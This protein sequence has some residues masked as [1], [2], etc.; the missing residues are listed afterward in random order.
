MLG[1]GGLLGMTVSSVG[2]IGERPS[3]VRRSV[4]I[5]GSRSSDISG[6]CCGG[7]ADTGVGS[8]LFGLLHV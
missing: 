1:D 8:E 7:G 4:C 5:I 3:R 2:T 6:R